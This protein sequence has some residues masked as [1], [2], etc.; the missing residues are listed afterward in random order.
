MKNK[1]YIHRSLLEGFSAACINLKIIAGSEIDVTIL[2]KNTS[3][4]YPM[5]EWI[6][7]QDVIINKYIDYQPIMN[8]VGMEMMMGWYHHGP[9]KTLIN[10]GVD[11]ITHQ[12]SS[13]GYHSVIKGDPA[14][15]GTF[16]LIEL[17]TKGKKAIVH[18]TTPFNRDIEKGVL[19][20]GMKAPDDLVYI[21]INNDDN[22]NIFNIQY[23]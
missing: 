11:F 9:G 19:L 8:R 3:E 14:K 21:D 1:T 20:G 6:K 17:D 4:W 5:D 2:Q 12:T 7:F 18:S 23:Y 13:L 22:I 15:I 10:K 16:D